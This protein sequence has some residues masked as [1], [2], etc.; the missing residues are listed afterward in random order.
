MN[1]SYDMSR[2][3]LRRY[4]ADYTTTATPP[5][6]IGG[7]YGLV[8]HLSGKVWLAE[9]KAY[10]TLIQRFRQGSSQ[11]YPSVLKGAV[12]NKTG[13]SLYLLT[14]PDRFD[15]NQCTTELAELDLL[16]ERKPVD[17]SGGGVLYVI[18]HNP[19]NN[20]F[21]AKNRMSHLT[22]FDV[23]RKFLYRLIHL[24]R[25]EVGVANKP[26][27]DFIDQHSQD[28]LI[29]RGFSIAPIGKFCN[30]DDSIVQANKYLIDN[31]FG[32]CLNRS[33]GGY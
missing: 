10:K 7:W 25:T 17:R 30:R 27:H 6:A 9:T 11:N 32:M 19:T 4:M 15:I 16:F 21:I 29:A 14:Q 3:I 23:L 13:L 28:I 31:R 22:E 8:D 18:R 33:I 26:L 24:P 12:E 1:N 20:F 2:G 5:K